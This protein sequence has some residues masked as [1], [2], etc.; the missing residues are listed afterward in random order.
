MDCRVNK[1]FNPKTCRYVKECKPGQVRDE[2]FRCKSIIRRVYKSKTVSRNK[3]KD[4][5]TMVN[6]NTSLSPNNVTRPK[7]NQSRPK[8]KTAKANPTNLKNENGPVLP[9]TVRFKTTP[10][11]KKDQQM[12][13]FIKK[14]KPTIS[15][16]WGEIKKSAIDVGLIKDSKDKALFQ[17]LLRKYL[18]VT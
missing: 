14:F 9:K 5:K 10:L 6:S 7:T 18:N 15:T 3:L 16:T 4:L 12:I 17:M 2:K 8:S 11:M 13:D 1:E